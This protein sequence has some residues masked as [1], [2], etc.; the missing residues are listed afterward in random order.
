MT[1]ALPDRFES[2][3]ALEEFMTRPSDGLVADLKGMWGGLALPGAV[4]RWS[5]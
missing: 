1:N 4:R 2:I 5:L 3:E